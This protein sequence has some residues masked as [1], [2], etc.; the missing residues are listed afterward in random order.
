MLARCSSAQ[1]KC[2]VWKLRAQSL[3]LVIHAFISD[4]TLIP[5]EI[6]CG[7]TPASAL[8]KPAMQKVQLHSFTSPT[9]HLRTNNE[10]GI[11]NHNTM[12]LPL[13]PVLC[14]DEW[15]SEGVIADSPLAT[16][17][18]KDNLRAADKSSFAMTPLQTKGPNNVRHNLNNMDFPVEKCAFNSSDFANA[19]D[20]YKGHTT[21]FPERY[22]SNG[23]RKSFPLSSDH[24]KSSSRD[25]CSENDFF[26]EISGDLPLASNNFISPGAC[27]SKSNSTFSSLTG[28]LSSTSNKFDNFAQDS[29]ASDPFR[30]FDLA[31]ASS[32]PFNDQINSFPS[33]ASFSGSKTNDLLQF[34][35]KQAQLIEHRHVRILSQMKDYVFEELASSISCMPD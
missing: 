32:N 19:C 18:R 26:N 16:T 7:F 30:S 2:L 27:D 24:F 17:L 20:S 4:L 28:G 31:S 3:H 10:K 8:S 15:Q 33:L 5:S 21:D 9:T 13:S 34:D 6:S 14:I 35:S 23:L 25:L 29:C 22:S 12:S 1:R 11:K